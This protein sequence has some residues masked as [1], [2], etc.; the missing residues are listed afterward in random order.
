[1]VRLYAHSS[2][3]ELE[4]EQAYDEAVEPIVV[5]VATLAFAALF[6]VLESREWLSRSSQYPVLI[7]EHSRLH[8][9]GV[10]LHSDI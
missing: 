10:I 9:H 4:F 6:S 5:A 2:D 8:L 3:E 1:V 7:S